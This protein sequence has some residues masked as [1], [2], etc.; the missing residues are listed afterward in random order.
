MG[1]LAKK[2]KSDFSFLK[3]SN[4][5]DTLE[6][7]DPPKGA[8]VP[9]EEQARLARRRAIAKRLSQSGQA[10]TVLTDTGGDRLGG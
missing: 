7:P 5:K 10:T 9:D 3:P 2:I 8:E 4:P 1:K 6:V